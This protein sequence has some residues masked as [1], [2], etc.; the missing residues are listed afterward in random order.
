MNIQYKN[1]LVELI[2]IKRYIRKRINQCEA[3]K[4]VILLGNIDYKMFILD[5]QSKAFKEILEKLELMDDYDKVR[6]K[7]M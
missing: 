5:G 7:L 1:G 6:K 4:K 3:E 2:G